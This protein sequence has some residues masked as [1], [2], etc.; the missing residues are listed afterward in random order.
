MNSPRARVVPPAVFQSGAVLASLIAG[1]VEVNGGAVELAWTVRPADG[2]EDVECARDTD[3]IEEVWLCARACTVIVDGQCTGETTC[4]VQSFPCEGFRGTT[5][6]EITSGRKE[7]WI[8]VKCA[9]GTPAD[10][11][12]P[13]PILRDI[14]DGEVTQ[15]NA[16]LITVP[17][18][19]PACP[20]SG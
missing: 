11:I 16:V 17:V 12:V 19:R 6:F 5:K 4:P 13:E 7:L 14:A 15:L 20:A 10:V 9:G 3:I 8:E 18:D 2:R 1:C